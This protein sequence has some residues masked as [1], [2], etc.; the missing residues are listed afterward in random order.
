MTPPGNADL[1]IGSSELCHVGAALRRLS[2]FGVNY[3]TAAIQ[4][5]PSQTGGKKVNANV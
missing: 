1:Q 4:I 3:R 5:S 2:T